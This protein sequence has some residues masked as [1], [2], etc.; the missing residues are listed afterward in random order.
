MRA[1]RIRRALVVAGALLAVL[2]GIVTVNTTRWIGMTFP[3]FLLMAN[4]V[5]PSIALPDWEAA[6]QSFQHQVIA[7]DGKRVATADEVYDRVATSTPGTVHRYLIRAPSGTLAT[8]EARARRF[9][10]LDYGL[11][12]GVYLSTG[13]AFFLT[14]LVVCWLKRSAASAGL[15]VQCITTGLFVV[16]AADLYGPHWFFR[17]H[18]VAE[19]M[20]AAG[21]IHLAMVFPTDRLG[22]RRGRTLALIYAPFALLAGLYQL[23]LTSPSG[24]TA[25]H[26]VASASHGVGALAII[27]VVAYELATTTSPLVRRRIG[28]VALGTLGAFALPGALMAASGILGGSVPLNAG[29]FTAFVFPLS[30]GYAIVQQD[31]FEIDVFLRRAATYAAALAAITAAYLA[32]LAAIGVLV[33]LQSLSPVTMAVLNLGILLAMAPIKARAQAAVDRVFFRKGYDAERVLSELSQA[34]SSARAL[35]DV[36]THTLRILADSVQPASAGIWLTDDGTRFRCVAP[37]ERAGATVT[38]PTEAAARLADGALLSRYSWAE[39]ST[40]AL[41]PFWNA[42]DAEIVVPIRSGH[43]V[44][45]ALGLGPKGSGRSYSEHDSVFLA[46]GASQVGLAIT[47][48][49]AFDQLAELNAGLEDQVRERTAALEIANRDLN[50]SYTAMQSAFRQL[51]QSQAG[52]IRADRL[53]TLGRL[54]ASVAHEVNTPLGAVL[55]ALQTLGD[56]GREYQESIAAAEVSPDDHREIAGE[57]VSTA[58][59]AAGWAR[60]AAAF[61]TRVK[62]HGREPHPAWRQHFTVRAVFEETRA[63]LGQRLRLECCELVLAEDPAEVGL[64]GDPARLGQVLVNLVSNALDAYEEQHSAE[65]RIVVSARA[66]DGDVEIAVRD[67]AGGMPPEVAARIFDELYTTKDA[68]RGTGLGLCIARNLVEES[69]GGTLRVETEQGVGSRFVITV[70]VDAAPLE[71]RPVNAA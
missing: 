60:K 42:L 39:R 46:A 15:L 1:D 69:F 25:V 7:L 50:R 71:A 53:A 65:S 11:L 54:A 22:V 8:V 6:R 34:L 47:N 51:E 67:T 14:G 68:G 49:R 33:P 26:L 5:V 59:T 4:R 66:V 18:V 56:L 43:F 35:A 3:G 23:A 61:I 2:V 58:G 30:L 55:N 13:V 64:V 41:P 37:A 28:V 17:L 10:G 31:L 21:F 16:T 62:S 36:E 63:L 48:A 44:L 20:L 29:A 40:D 57:I 12:F 52:L 9:S 38:V 70:P 24:Y 19:A 27:G 32:T 45:G